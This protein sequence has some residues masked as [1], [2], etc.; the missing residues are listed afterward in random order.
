MSLVNV[1][2]KTV[3]GMTATAAIITA[4]PVLGEVGA[5]SA[6]GSVVSV[7]LSAGSALYD[8]IKSNK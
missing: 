3:I 1:L 7:A 8:E 5:I 6:A 2:E 4:L